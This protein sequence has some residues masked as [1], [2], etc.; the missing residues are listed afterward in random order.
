MR[1]WEAKLVYN[2]L[3]LG[4]DTAL[5]RPDKVAAYLHSAFDEDPTVEWFVTILLDRKNRAIGR[6]IVS[7]GTATCSLAHPREV[8]KAAILGGA[9]GVIV[10]HNH[11][12]GDPT[13]SRTDIRTTR[14][15]REAS[16]I[17]SIDLL[18]HVI[19]GVKEADPAGL[20]Y[21]SFCEAGVL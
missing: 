18:D 5:D 1:I 12:S 3:Q 13:P 8:F 19:V 10:A 9:S 11:P 15:L 2:L 6:H 7:K 17:I 21:Y 4:E 14:A 16:K 20:G